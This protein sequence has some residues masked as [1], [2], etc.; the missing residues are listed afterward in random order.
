MARKQVTL[1]SD[2]AERYE[3]LRLAVEEQRDGATPS[4]AETLRLMMDQFDPAE[5]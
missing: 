1:R 2:D 4:N 3:A 5:I